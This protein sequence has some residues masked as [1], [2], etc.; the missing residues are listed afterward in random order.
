MILTDQIEAAKQIIES[1]GYTNFI[2]HSII[3]NNADGYVIRI[4]DETGKNH[5][6]FCNSLFVYSTIYYP[7][8]A[9]LVGSEIQRGI[10]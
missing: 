6:I 5:L 4:T 7:C 8:R 1:R 2:M 10:K 3:G 9:P